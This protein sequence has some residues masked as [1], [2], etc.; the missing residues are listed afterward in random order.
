MPIPLKFEAAGAGVI[1][2]L[3]A[4]LFGW[5]EHKDI[6]S[7]AAI[8]KKHD[9]C[10]S[11]LGGK[12]NVALTCD[13]AIVTFYDRAQHAATCDQALALGGTAPECSPAVAD[14]FGTNVTLKT[15]L[16]S[17]V[18]DRDAAI[19]RAAARATSD[20]QRKAQDDR[21]LAAAPRQPDGL[22]VCDA[23]CLR[24]RFEVDAR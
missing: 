9:D 15:Q 23:Q 11:A 13:A 21:A 12:G 2:L 19:A 5:A 24:D 20:A 1:L 18:A 6:V 7:Q 16:Q 3:V 17:I 4:S 22:I 10:L 14:L 8:I